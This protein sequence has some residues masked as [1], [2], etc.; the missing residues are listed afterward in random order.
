MA[1]V[2]KSIAVSKIIERMKWPPPASIEVARVYGR[3]AT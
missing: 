1:V 3:L 2:E